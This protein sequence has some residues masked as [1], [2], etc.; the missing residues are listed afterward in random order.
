PDPDDKKPENWDER[1][2]IPDSDAVKPDD[3]DEDASMEIEDEEAVKP[4][5]W[6]DD[7][8]E[9]VDDN[10]ATK[11]EDWDDEDDGE[12]E[13]PKI[14][15]PKCE[16]APGCGDFVLQDVIEK[17]EKQPILTIGDLVSIIVVVAT[18]ILRLLFGRKKPQVSCFLCGLSLCLFPP[19]G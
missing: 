18:A 15:N 5:R 12:W 13:A 11:P 17:A 16:A 10:E 14:D 2:K 19:A 4:E 9:E 6:L 1:A 7:E 8:P 3:W